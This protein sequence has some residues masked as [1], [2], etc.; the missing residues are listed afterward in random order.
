[1]SILKGYNYFVYI[2]T[3]KK[4]YYL[5]Y[6]ER[7]Q[8]IDDAI[9]REKQLKKWRRQKKE[10]LIKGFNPDWNFLNDLTVEW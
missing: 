4:C 1:M 3:N 2:L 7:Y 6:Y 10:F 8:F 9:E 5:V